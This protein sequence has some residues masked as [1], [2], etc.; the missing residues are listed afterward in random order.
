MGKRWAQIESLKLPARSCA[1]QVIADRMAFVQRQLP[2]AAYHSAEDVEYVH[3]LRVGCRRAAAALRAFQPLFAAK[4]RKLKKWLGRIRL[5]AGPA[6]DIDVLLPRFQDEPPDNPVA[7]YAIARLT[8]ERVEAQRRLVRVA[9]KASRGKL[10][11]SVNESL[12][13]LA[14]EKNSSRPTWQSFAQS[15][16]HLA[17]ATLLQLSLVETPTLAELHQMRIAGKRLRYSIEIFHNALDKPWREAVYP[18]LVDLQDRLGVIND[19]ASAQLRFQGW[20]ATLRADQLSAALAHRAVAEHE[21]AVQLSGEFLAWWQDGHAAN[22]Q[23]SLS[24]ASG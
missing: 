2:L 1:R 3:Q 19:H 4:P 22:L 5:S 20:L 18:L 6:R 23:A 17:S 16:L 10:I 21:L 12:K 15:A 7:Q 14:G 24:E 11:A 8:G 13:A 9:E